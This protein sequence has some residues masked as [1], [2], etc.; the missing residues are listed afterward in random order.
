MTLETRGEIEP[1]LDQIG[2][3]VWFLEAI[4][5]VWFDF[6]QKLLRICV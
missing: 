4:G 3:S 5:L 1:K 2:D 6:W